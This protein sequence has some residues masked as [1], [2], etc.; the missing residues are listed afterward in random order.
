MLGTVSGTGT[1]DMDIAGGP[2]EECE[3]MHA[4][5]KAPGHVSGEE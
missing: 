1:D 4:R 3:Q 2:W 5:E